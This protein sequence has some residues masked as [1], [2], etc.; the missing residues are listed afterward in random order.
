VLGFKDMIAALETGNYLVASA[1]L[2]NSKLAQEAAGRV[3]EL[4]GDVTRR[5]DRL[6]LT[7]SET[8]VDE[9]SVKVAVPSVHKLCLTTNL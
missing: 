8:P 2:T 5:R 4:T 9:T 3:E 6:D 7:L 1:A